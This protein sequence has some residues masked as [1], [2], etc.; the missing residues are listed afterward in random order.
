MARQLKIEQPFDLA[1]SLKM[2]QA[3]RWRERTDG[4]FSGVLGGNLVHI[5][6]TDTGVEYR[7]GGPEGERN[8]TDAD[9]D[10]LRGYF[11]LDDDIEAIYA[12][13]SR[14]T[15]VARLVE[16]IGEC[17]FCDR[18]LGSAWYR[19]SARETQVSMGSK[20]MWRKL[21]RKA[22]AS[23]VWTMICGIFSQL[24]KR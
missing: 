5:L 2:G 20:E 8:A 23:S 24:R 3:F 22:N 14:D 1:L 6:Q 19:T 18:N 7:M 11:R 15:I 17:A 21:R 10:L 12:D 4:W 9:D 13:I 16:N